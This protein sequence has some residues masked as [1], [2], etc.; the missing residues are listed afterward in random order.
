M[1]RVIR[2]HEAT[3]NRLQKLATPLVDTPATVIDTLLDFYDSQP[4][5][6]SVLEPSSNQTI[7]GIPE[8]K[9]FAGG[10][11]SGLAYRE[12][13]QK[14]VVVKIDGK[15][16]KAYSLADLYRQ[17]LKH[18]CSSGNIDKVKP[19]LPLA[20]SGKRYLIA[21]KPIHPRG[22]NFFCSIEYGGFYMETHKSYSC[23]IL[24]LQKLLDL[25]N[26]SLTYIE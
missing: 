17:V 15:T 9:I 11:T 23:G 7:I 5:E 20:T 13:R 18:L 2:I 6:I 16:F 19:Y 8:N 21:T 1:S 24:H 12:P 22:N 26:L 10:P 4:S 25:C 14:G 3:F